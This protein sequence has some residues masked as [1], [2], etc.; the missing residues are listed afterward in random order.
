MPQVWA[1]QPGSFP[2]NA[3]DRDLPQIMQLKASFQTF[4]K[5]E[6]CGKVSCGGKECFGSIN[7]TKSEF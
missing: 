1:H 5:P 3:L 6:H 4:W 2:E 7:S